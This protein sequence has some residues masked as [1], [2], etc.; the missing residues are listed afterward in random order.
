MPLISVLMG[1]YNCADTLGASIEAIQNQTV[2]DWELIIC[3]DGSTDTTVEVVRAYAAEDDRIVLLQNEKN[4]GL[5]YG[6]NRCIEAA[7]GEFCARMDG[8][9]LCEPTRFEIELAVLREHPEYALVSTTM[10]RFDENGVY[11]VPETGEA[12]V[13]TKKDFVKGSPFCHAPAMIRT[14]AYRQVNGYRDIERTRGVEDYDLWFRMYAAGMQGC[15]LR[16]PLYSMFDGREAA[17]R[18]SFR[19]RKNE[20]WV[21]KEGYRM[22]KTPWLSRVYVCK[23][24]LLG[25]IPQWLYKKLR[26]LK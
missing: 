17:M 21:R 2:T 11:S 3:D 4:H 12:Y 23:P 13:V 9:D 5:S 25:L 15:M 14:E 18:R 20:A 16:Q 22:L 1:A 7:R 26:R 24:I 10:K 19:R 6:L 8:D